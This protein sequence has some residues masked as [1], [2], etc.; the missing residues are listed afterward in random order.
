[1]TPPS[2]PLSAV[3]YCDGGASP[4]P[5]PAGSG[6]HGYIYHLPKEK[7]KPTRIN[8]YLAT[9]VGYVH[10]RD[11]KPGHQGVVVDQYFDAV[12]SQGI[13]TNNIGE[14]RAVIL[15]LSNATLQSVARLHIL[16]DSKLVVKG[17][18][19]WMPNWIRNQ[20]K[21]SDGE[22]VSNL[23]DW[24]ALNALLTQYKEMGG[25]FTID[26]ILGHNND[27]GN[28]RADM[29][30][31]LG[32]NYASG[33]QEGSSFIFDEPKTLGGPSLEVHPFMCLKRLYFNTSSD[34]NV[35][36]VYYQTDG[37]DDK[38][39]MGK[40]SSESAFSVVKLTFPDVL[41]ESLIE[42]A[43]SRISPV[44]SILYTRV[45]RLNEKTLSS[46]VYRYGSRVFSSHRRNLNLNFLDRLPVVNEVKPGELPLR[47]IDTLAHLEDV[48]D[49]FRD[50]AG[51]KTAVE[52][53]KEKLYQFV[54]ITDEFYEK[55]IKRAKGNE[56][57]VWTL[58]KAFT[59]GSQKHIIT[60]TLETEVGE[61]EIQ[62]SLLF[63]GDLPPRNTL[64]RLESLSPQMHLVVWHESPKALRY[65]V[66]VQTDEA[67]GIW[68]NY[69]ASLYLL[70]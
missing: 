2:S 39:V 52:Q 31:T 17:I 61:R 56:I 53:T 42:A 26:W 49:F 1:M 4:N 48:L 43:S 9:T 14:I 28:T 66:I 6:I 15:C 7:E 36:G 33:N 38:F 54:D 44:N 41:M 29:L 21:K 60:R 19:E 18:N 34:F 16:T 59:S 37:S 57:E 3:A 10:Q 64:K 67:V 23:Q 5:G 45:D 65:G 8:L 35:P 22:S 70:K 27:F 32:V 25:Q 24:Q 51:A 63:G 58:H 12:E 20:W 47:G 46:F 40:R 69:H 11:L 50:R 62:F 68:S 55:S 13:A 30:A